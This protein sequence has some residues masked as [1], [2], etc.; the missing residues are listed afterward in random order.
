M[1][2]MH[3]GSVNVGS[4]VSAGLSFG[5]GL[6]LV[7]YMFHAILS[8]GR[9]VKTVIVCNNCSVKNPDG[10]RFCGYCGHALYPPPRIRCPNCGATVFV[11][12]FCGNCGVK[13]ARA[14]TKKR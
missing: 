12:E 10:F 2:Y 9:I 7:P 5:L 6:V 8:P 3:N 4:S 14:K 11:M 13:I 1:A